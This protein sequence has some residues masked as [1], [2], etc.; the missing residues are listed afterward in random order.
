MK[1]RNL[2]KKQKNKGIALLIAVIATSALLLASV[3]ISDIAYKQQLISYAGRESKEAFYAADAGLE[4]ALYHDL[5]IEN[6]FPTPNSPTQ[7]INGTLR[8]N[9]TTPTTTTS[10]SPGQPSITTFSYNFSGS[11]T[12]VSVQKSLSGVYVRTNVVSRGYNTTCSGI[13]P[14]PNS[15]L[16]NVERALEAN[17]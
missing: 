8:C 2:F 3:A 1:L 10:S 14:A 11:C 9:G 6:F 15:G 16:R 17:Y 12:I 4:C 5:K 7:N 13:P